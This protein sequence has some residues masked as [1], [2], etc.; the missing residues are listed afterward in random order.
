MNAAMDA[1]AIKRA[2][3]GALIQYIVPSSDLAVSLGRGSVT[4]VCILW[5][6]LSISGELTCQH[7]G[8]VLG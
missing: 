5:P 8:A 6:I 4:S 7:P 1:Q 2:V 3:Q